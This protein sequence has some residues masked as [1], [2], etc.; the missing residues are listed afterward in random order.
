MKKEIGIWSLL[1]FLCAVSS[2]KEKS[3]SY[4]IPEKENHIIGKI[5][6]NANDIPL[7]TDIEITDSYYVF[8][9]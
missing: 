4:Q 9:D 1:L 6:K 2:C 5:W 3:L 8:T 7:Y